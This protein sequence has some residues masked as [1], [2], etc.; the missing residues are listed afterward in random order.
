MFFILFASFS[1]AQDL[2]QDHAM[3]SVVISLYFLY[4]GT[5]PWP[6]FAFLDFD[7]FEEY[8]PVIL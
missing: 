3:Y 6:F 8:G 4:S 1:P 7:I 5:V 2:F